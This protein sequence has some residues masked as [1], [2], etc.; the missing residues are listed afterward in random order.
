[1]FPSAV[2]RAKCVP[3]H[4]VRV[5]RRGG[6]ARVRGARAALPSTAAGAGPQ[7]VPLLPHHRASG[8]GAHGAT[9]P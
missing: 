1:M 7:R 6:R 3:A 9:Q 5:L 2:S 4:G 8:V